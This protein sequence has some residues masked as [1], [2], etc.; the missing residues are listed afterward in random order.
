[1][2]INKSPRRDRADWLDSPKQTRW[3]LIEHYDYYD[4]WTKKFSY[5]QLE[6]VLIISNFDVLLT[7]VFSSWSPP[8]LSCTTS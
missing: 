5:S 4:L 2:N 3:D 6:L 1:M 7:H 8:H